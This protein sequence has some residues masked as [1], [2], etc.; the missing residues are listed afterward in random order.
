MK[1][2]QLHMYIR[3]NWVL[4]SA[5]LGFTI[6]P[7]AMCLVFLM[8]YSSGNIPLD[9]WFSFY[10]IYDNEY[11]INNI[12]LSFIVVSYILLFSNQFIYFLEAQSKAFNYRG[13]NTK[14]KNINL[15]C[16]FIDITVLIGIMIFILKVNGYHQIIAY[17][18][19]LSLS[20][21][22]A[23]SVTDILMWY[24][25]FLIRKT[26]RDPLKIRLC[27]NNISF[28]RKSMM[29]INFPALTILTLSFYLHCWIVD[30]PFYHSY[31]NGK[32][33]ENIENFDLFI[34]G[35]ETSIIFTSIIITQIVF[36]VLKI[37]WSFTKYQIEQNLPLLPVE[38]K[39]VKKLRRRKAKTINELSV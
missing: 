36:A 9:R 19:V 1:N 26:L 10:G 11:H 15:L 24:Q 17:N 16:Q 5:T 34:D 4:L 28:S 35:F 37:K 27:N 31:F 3:K 29:L 12:L 25:E 6:L 21:F 7:I 14:F 23:F 32:D 18:R 2:R 30:D 38:M 13:S 8:N 22:L 33:F 39:Q 20:V